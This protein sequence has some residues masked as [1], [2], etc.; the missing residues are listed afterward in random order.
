MAR[1]LVVDDTHSA[2]VVLTLALEGA[3]HVVVGDAS[4][5]PEAVEL[6]ARTNPD[7]VVLDFE[8]PGTMTGGDAMPLIRDVV[9]GAAIVM[10]SGSPG[11]QES[12]ADEHI[13]KSEGV[14]AL[15]AAVSRLAPG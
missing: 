8:L 2:R 10:F 12:G 9:P 13:D 7:V 14:A 11:A 5:G 15:L 4:A 6:A 1:V 3:G